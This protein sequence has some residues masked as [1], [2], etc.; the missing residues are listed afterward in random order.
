MD[1]DV[2]VIGADVL[3]GFEMCDPA[4]LPDGLAWASAAPSRCLGAA[5]VRCSP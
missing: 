5:R 1:T 2:L 3:P 4:E